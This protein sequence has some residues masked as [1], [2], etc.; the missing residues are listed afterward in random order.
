M[1]DHGTYRMKGRAVRKA[2]VKAGYQQKQLAAEAGISRQYLCDIERGRRFAERR[3]DV[4]KRI[5]EIL[6]V[7]QARLEEYVPRAVAS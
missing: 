5:A 2:R 4:R 3:P 7:P 1:Q 6:G